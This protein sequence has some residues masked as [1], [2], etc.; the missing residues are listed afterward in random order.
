MESMPEQDLVDCFKVD[1]W[2]SDPSHV[3][4]K[5]RNL[6]AWRIAVGVWLT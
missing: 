5:D 6:W 4:A 3:G 2:N 1:V